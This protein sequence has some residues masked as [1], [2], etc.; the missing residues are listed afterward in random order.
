M[1]GADEGLGPG[2]TG[3]APERREA[4]GSSAAAVA[5]LRRLIPLG[6]WVL[7]AIALNRRV[8]VQTF[9]PETAD[10]AEAWIE[11]R[12]RTKNLY[13]HVN[14]VAE[15]VKKKAT[16]AQIKEVTYLHVD[17]DPCSGFDMWTAVAA[18]RRSG[19]WRNRSSWTANP[20]GRKRSS[21]LTSSS[22]PS[23]V[24]TTAITSTE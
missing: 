18:T 5:F 6:F 21:A 12:I 24:A 22:R 9:G 14:Q 4:C 2:D 16:K 15:P 19:C 1:V 10:K 17:A 13:F 7:M 11:E 23:S 3:P 20:P 8:E